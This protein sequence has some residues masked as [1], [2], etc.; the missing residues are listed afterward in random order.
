MIP[1]RPG[2][3]AQAA[4]P[5]LEAGTGT[6]GASVGTGP[7]TTRLRSPAGSTNRAGRPLARTGRPARKRAAAALRPG[8]GLVAS[9]PMRSGLA[10]GNMGC[11]LDR[12]VVAVIAMI[13]P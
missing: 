2:R 11:Y 5:D 4:R 3:R 13:R 1:G 8:A 9:W 12:R 10:V 6:W 7:G